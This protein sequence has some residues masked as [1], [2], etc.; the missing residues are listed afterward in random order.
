MKWYTVAANKGMATAQCNLGEIYLNG[1]GIP[2]DINA[3]AYWFE[4]AAKRDYYYAKHMLNA[5]E[6]YF[7]DGYGNYTLADRYFEG[8]GVPQNYDFAFK[9]YNEDVN[10]Y[11]PHSA[12]KIGVMYE[13]GFGT[14]KNLDSALLFY[15]NSAENG[16]SCGQL[17]LGIMLGNDNFAKFDIVKADAWITVSY[18][19]GLKQ[20]LKVKKT[21]ESRMTP[22]QILIAHEKARMWLKLYNSVQ[23]SDCI[24][25]N[26]IGIDKGWGGDND[27]KPFVTD[28]DCPVED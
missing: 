10:N 25:R 1:K 24:H 17:N 12:F 19:L 28:C 20:A 16:D 6:D 2:Q 26:P 8:K 9:L 11:S 27:E 23:V 14:T 13:K 22:E 21:I 4:K 7:T 5:I 3:A 15:T 18:K